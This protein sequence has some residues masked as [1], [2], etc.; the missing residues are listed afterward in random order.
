M[1][2]KR[3]DVSFVTVAWP[4]V[5]S[6]HLRSEVKLVAVA[7]RGIG[8]HPAELSKWLTASSLR[9]RGGVAEVESR[10]NR[11]LD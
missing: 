3:G 5:T 1:L 7:A 10:E 6:N 2:Q 8:R 11:F 4:P 9:R